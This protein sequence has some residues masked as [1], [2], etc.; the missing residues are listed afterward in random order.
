MNVVRIPINAA[1]I[2]RFRRLPKQKQKLLKDK[3]AALLEQELN[4]SATGD[5]DMTDFQEAMGMTNIDMVLT[6]GESYLQE[7]KWS[8]AHE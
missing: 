2:E 5:G 6:F 3:V 1:A 4:Q 8:P 7:K